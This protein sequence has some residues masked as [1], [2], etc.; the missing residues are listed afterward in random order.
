MIRTLTHDTG[1]LAGLR[2]GTTQLQERTEQC[3]WTTRSNCI[4]T[5][6]YLAGEIERDEFVDL[7]LAHAD[8]LSMLQRQDL[9]VEGSLV[10]WHL[11]LRATPFFMEIGFHNLFG[12]TERDYQRIIKEDGS[13]F[14]F[15]SHMGVVAS[16]KPLSV[17]HRLECGGRLVER[18]VFSKADRHART[19][20]NGHTFEVAFYLPSALEE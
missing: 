4:G 1:N 6:L 14:T 17:T 13:L 19:D 12:G 11:E 10:A 15:T 5:A 8:Y 20:T 9:P 7:H 18:Q 2:R 3:R 16:L